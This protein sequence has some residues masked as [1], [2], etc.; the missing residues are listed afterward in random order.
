M[1]PFATLSLVAALVAVS[2]VLLPQFWIYVFMILDFYT[3]WVSWNSV[4]FHKWS[5]F[6][7]SLQPER[8]ELP[9]PEVHVD[10]ATVV[11]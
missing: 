3:P 10:T 8:P 6:V 4:F 1:K 9:I 2:L 7:V 5:N 11:R